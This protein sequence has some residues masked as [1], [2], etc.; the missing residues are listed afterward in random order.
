MGSGC[1]CLGGGNHN[2]KCRGAVVGTPDVYF[3]VPVFCSLPGSRYSYPVEK[4]YLLE[5]ISNY[6]TLLLCMVLNLG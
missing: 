6:L 5:L 2:R 1:S 4:A 3:A